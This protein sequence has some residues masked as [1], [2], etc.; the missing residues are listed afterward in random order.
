MKIVHGLRNCNC[1][2]RGLVSGKCYRDKYGTRKHYYEN[3]HHLAIHLEKMIN[4][5]MPRGQKIS[6]EDAKR[7]ANYWIKEFMEGVYVKQPK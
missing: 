5:K 7:E 6:F 1:G 2:C 4:K 3:K